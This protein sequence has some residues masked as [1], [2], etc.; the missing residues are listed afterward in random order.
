MTNDKKIER[1]LTAFYNGDTTQEEETLL[2]KFFNNT[3]ISENWSAD[4]DLFYALYDSSHIHIPEESLKRLEHQIDNH[5]KKTGIT[6]KNIFLRTKKTKR[7]YISIGSIAA[8]VLLLAGIF[9]FHDKSSVKND[10]LTDTLTDPQEAAI[11]VE[12]VLALVSS[13]LNK[14]L[15]PLEKVKYSIN[16]TNELLNENL[17]LNK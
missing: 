17:N 11:V 7:L 10:V 4:R 12:K 9:F 5:I 8:A 13:N 1:L 16:K 14:G 6:S 2:Q 15:S 3:N